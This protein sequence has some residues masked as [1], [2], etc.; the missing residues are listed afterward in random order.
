MKFDGTNWM[1][2]G[3]TGFSVGIIG[4]YI[5]FA[6][7]PLDGE[8][9]VAFSD[10]ANSQKATVMK[11]DGTNWVNLGNPGFSAGES[12][13]T[14]LA[15]HPLDGE[16]Y[17]AYSD[18]ENSQKATV[19]KFDGTNWV[20]QGNAGFSIGK[21]YYLSLAFSPSDGESYVAYTD[22]INS[23]K[24][25]VMKFD[26]NNWVNM[27]NAGFTQGIASFP[28]LAFSPSGQPYVA[29]MDIQNGETATVMKYDSDFTG[30]N[31]QQESRLILYPN[32]TSKKI[33]IDLMK[34]PGSLNYIEINDIK[35]IRMFETQTSDRKTV[36]DVENYPAGIYI[37]K[38]NTKS[39]NWIEQFC[40]N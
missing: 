31:E 17:V 29:F 23:F 12:N 34:F 6:F 22:S 14:S 25:T 32:P 40:K 26:G 30:I 36:V 8:P 24:A 1:S 10:W 13:Y 28:S 9:Y 3:Y 37:V 7:N 39:S 35:G 11:F 33:T 15:F 19:M 18:W 5:S 27:G 20:D 16:A 21:A 38:V 4:Y 2:V